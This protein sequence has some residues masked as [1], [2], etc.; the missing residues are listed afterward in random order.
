MP[1]L[2]GQGSLM[3]VDGIDPN[4]CNKT[5]ANSSSGKSP[6]QAKQLFSTDLMTGPHA[7][8]Q[9]HVGLHNLRSIFHTALKRTPAQ[10]AADHVMETE[11]SLQAWEEANKVSRVQALNKKFEASALLRLPTLSAQS[12][13]GITW[14]LQMEGINCTSPEGNNHADMEEY[15]WTLPLLDLGQCI[16]AN[17]RGTRHRHSTMAARLSEQLKEQERIAARNTAIVETL[18]KLES[19]VNQTLLGEAL[20]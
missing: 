1:Q 8:Q 9:H 11:I 4:M 5:C 12:N 16:T 18:S 20:E 10:V 2:E 13:K 17:P 6:A 14:S 19:T 3:T 15:D 7:R